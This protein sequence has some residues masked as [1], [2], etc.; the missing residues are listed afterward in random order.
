MAKAGSPPDT[1]ADD[2]AN[3]PAP[4]PQADVCDR[5]GPAPSGRWV[6][7][8]PPGRIYTHIP[9]TVDPGDVIAW[10]ELPAGDGAWEPTD[11]EVTRF[12]DNHRPEPDDN[13]LEG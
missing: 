2:A 4:D 3:E 8:G 7:T 9:V 1:T 10:V 13:A 11:D 6:Y 12:P 5:R